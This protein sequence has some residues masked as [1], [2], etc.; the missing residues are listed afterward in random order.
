M[1]KA[2]E[3]AIRPGLAGD[4]GRIDETGFVRK[5]VLVKRK[6]V[7]LPKVIQQFVDVV[8]GSLATSKGRA[9]R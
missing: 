3:V 1:K 5:L 8:V 9:R 7:N 2:I 4:I 6:S